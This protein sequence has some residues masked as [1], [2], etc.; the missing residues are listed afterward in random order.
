M[1]WSFERWL[2]SPVE[3]KKVISKQVKKAAGARLLPHRDILLQAIRVKVANFY[4]TSF[5]RRDSRFDL[6]PDNYLSFR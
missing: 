2:L 3:M 4:P 1:A 5:R 6:A